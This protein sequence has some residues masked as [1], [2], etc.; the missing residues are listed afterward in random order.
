MAPTVAP[1]GGARARYLAATASGVL[2][3]LSYPPF[4]LGPLSLVALVPLLWAWRDASVR[5]AAGLGFVG[6]V[7][8]FTIVLWWVR[9]F[10]VVAIFPLVAAMAGSWALV[11]AAAGWLR[12]LGFSSPWLT[13][14]AWITGE[15]VIARFPLQGFPWGEVG[16]TLH[17]WP[18]ARAL[19]SWGG[20]A[21]VSFVVVAWNGLVIDLWVAVRARRHHAESTGRPVIRALAA[22][23]SLVVAVAVLAATRF[24]P[25]PTGHLRFAL[26]QGNDKNRP[27]TSEELANRYLPASHF[28]LADRL[29]GD[30]DL[31][32]FPESSMDDDPRVDPYL[33]DHIDA[34]A[35]EHH[36]TVIANAITHDGKGRSYN[37]NIA[38][39][40]D[41][42]VAGS[43]SKQHLVPF[44]EYVPWRDQLGFI[45]ELQQIPV[46]LTAGSTHR[47]L[48]VDGHRVGTVICFESSFSPLVRQFVR[49]GAEAIVVTTNNRSYRRSGNSA[50]HVAMSQMRAAET[51][52]PVL[53]SSISG[54]TAV[55]D[56]TGAVRRSTKLF[57][58]AVVTGTI[59]TVRGET[60]YVR[61][62]EW[63]V[64][65]AALALV[66]VSGLGLWRRR[67]RRRVARTVDSAAEDHQEALR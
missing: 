48:A 42:S 22:L 14:A 26:V 13:A 19:A 29:R 16:L 30:Y 34:L 41:G 21:L 9:Y 37:T 25:A 8:Y 65:L 39:R 5:R 11:G 24:E 60:P 20:V 4:H 51:A 44:G 46:D 12:R 28:R 47:T 55:I 36:A 62:G 64:L 31:I 43:Y 1:P 38:F 49:E 59:T 56:S 23:T 54:I 50:Q 67:A 61:W 52:R 66:A 2:L 3:A 6:G 45:D 57:E 17:D 15:A 33:R 53:H 63:P 18:A 32:V 40:P 10:G 7:V 27:L 58:N 35:R